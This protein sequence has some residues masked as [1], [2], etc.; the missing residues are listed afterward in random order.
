[1]LRTVAAVALCL[2]MPAVALAQQEASTFPAWLAGAWL[3]DDGERWTEEFWTP[4][5]GGIMIGASREGEG[6]TLRSWESIRI[7][8]K[9]DGALAY[10]P[11]P[12]GGV[13]VEFTL[14][15]QDHRSIEFANPAHDFP[16]RIRYWRQGDRLHAEIALIDGGRAIQ[17][18]YSPMGE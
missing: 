1:M 3:N 8:R 11:M 12:N 10:I 6:D 18:S 2:A 5:R 13:P 16:Q 9:A 4:P 15:K 17:W 7:L 14:V